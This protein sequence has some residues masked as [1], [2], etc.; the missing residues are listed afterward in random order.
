MERSGNLE[1]P[2]FENGAGDTTAMAQQMGSGDFAE[3]VHQMEQSD[4]DPRQ[5]YALVKKRI[6]EFRRSGKAVPDELSR[7]EKS[8]LTECM[9]ASQGR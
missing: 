5:C 8:L 6:T 7:L 4:D 9:H 2:F 3:L 1:I